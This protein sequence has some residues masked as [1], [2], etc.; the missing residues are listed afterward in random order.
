MARRYSPGELLGRAREELSAYGDLVRE[1]PYQVHDTLEQLR[2]GEVEVQF[3]H[4]G[5]DELI[6]KA[7][8]VFNRLAIA[9]VASASILGAGVFAA[10]GEG[11]EILGANVLALAALLFSMVLA[12]LLAFSIVR[13]GRI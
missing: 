1:L 10:A 9:I 2:D 8:V 5:L 13:S 3:R 6:G 11:P 12:G 7:D 4:R